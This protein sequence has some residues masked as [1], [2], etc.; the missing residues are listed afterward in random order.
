MVAV[1]RRAWRPTITEAARFYDVPVHR[2]DKWLQRGKVH[3][4]EDGTVNVRCLGLWLIRHTLDDY[5]ADHA[6]VCQT[7]T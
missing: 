7:L 6:E 1:S 3:R 2:V 4:N 5:V